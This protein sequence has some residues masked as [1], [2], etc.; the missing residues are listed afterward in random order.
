MNETIR[1]K[2]TFN[3]NYIETIDNFLINY[4]IIYKSFNSDVSYVFE[5]ADT[6]VDKIIYYLLL[7][8]SKQIKIENI[9]SIN[10]N[11]DEQEVGTDKPIGSKDAIDEN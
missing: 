1:L 6:D 4:N 3:F 2:I 10:Q 5:V 8:T 9:S 11:Q 7:L